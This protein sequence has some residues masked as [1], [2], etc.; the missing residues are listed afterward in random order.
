MTP[1]GAGYHCGCGTRY[2]LSAGATPAVRDAYEQACTDHGM[3][4]ANARWGDARDVTDMIGSAVAEIAA[5]APIRQTLMRA[6]TYVRMLTDEGIEVHS[7]IAETPD[8][9]RVHVAGGM[10]AAAAMVLGW[11][12]GHSIFGDIA[13]PME[14]V[15][16]G[17]SMLTSD[18]V[19]GAVTA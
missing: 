5:L 3:I 7:V 6:D 17:D 1:Y 11:T 15:C 13:H 18:Y 4:C 14:R 19:Y 10:V 2:M 12:S 8:L 9:V 16:E